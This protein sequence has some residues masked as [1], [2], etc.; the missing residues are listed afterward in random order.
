MKA[1]VVAI[2]STG[3]ALAI[4]A[5]TPVE[6]TA[7]RA[8][9]VLDGGRETVLRWT[10]TSLP[11]HVEEWEAFLSLDGGRYYAVRI[12]PHLDAGRRSF[13]WRVPNV[14]ASNARILIRIGD[15][16]AEE[17]IEF[18]QT[19]TIVPNVSVVELADPHAAITEASG[20]RALP[21]AAP[22]VEWVSGDRRGQGLVTRRH[23][24]HA[25]IDARHLPA[26]DG[27]TVAAHISNDSLLI[28]RRPSSAILKRARAVRGVRLPLEPRPLLLLSTRLNI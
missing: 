26:G 25:G 15:E 1:V 20:E 7:P 23:R 3:I 5:A 8:G 10:A 12:T 18:P 4:S 6:L 2:A 21:T 14:A 28:P 22:I 27:A 13:R 11:E 19:F 17:A 16:R 24:D 9:A